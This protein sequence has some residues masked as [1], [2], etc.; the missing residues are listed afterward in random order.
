MLEAI[1]IISFVLKIVIN[2]YIAV[3]W[4]R[5]IL[6]W[7]RVLNP[8]WRPKGF[9]V[10]LVETVY[11]IT[12]PPLRFIRRLLPPLRV[13]TFSLDFGWMITLVACWILLALLP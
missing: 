8:S 11:T 4:G 7:V 2:L 3:L 5:F 13:G 12:D 6:D 1:L 10:I 9:L